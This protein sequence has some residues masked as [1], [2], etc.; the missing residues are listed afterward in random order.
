MF[1]YVLR[2]IVIN[3]CPTTHKTPAVYFFNS[4]NSRSFYRKISGSTAL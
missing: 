2:L 4:N 1:Q 3:Q